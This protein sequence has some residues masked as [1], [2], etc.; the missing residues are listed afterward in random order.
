VR[1]GTPS[2][3]CW[4]TARTMSHWQGLFSHRHFDVKFASRAL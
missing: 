2:S 1:N 4:I 3:I